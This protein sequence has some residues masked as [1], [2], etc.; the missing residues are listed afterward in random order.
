MKKLTLL[1]LLIWVSASAFGQVISISG[2]VTD[3]QDKPVAF[4][5]IKDAQHNYAT[6]TDP[7]GAFT[8][9]ADPASRLM[10]TCNNYEKAV[11]VVDNQPTIKIVMKRIVAKGS[12]TSTSSSTF[13]M[14]EIGGNDRSA[15]PGIS[16][17]TS[18]EEL[19]GSPYL[20]NDW[21]HG[22]AVSPADSII[23]KDNYLFNY[24]KIAG[25]LLY[26]DDGKT[27]YAVDKGKVKKFIL[28]DENGQSVTF[29]YVPSI[30]PKHYLQVLASGSKYVIYKNLNTKFLRADFQTN[31][32]TSSGNNYDSYVDEGEYYIVKVPGGQPQ[33]V[34]LKRRAIKNAFGAEANKASKY[35]EAHDS[36]EVDDNFLKGLGEAMN[37]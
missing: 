6:F 9:S 28:F 36:D 26:T 10:A 30:D 15:R 31:G 34:G 27:V 25:T 8:I 1:S 5:F 13:E 29:E 18:K 37:Q 17:G 7:N 4:A 23:Q 16:F 35:M 22:Y 33:K 11:V 24:E 12:N 20:F 19:H 21:V 14:Q 3:E 2:A 32:I